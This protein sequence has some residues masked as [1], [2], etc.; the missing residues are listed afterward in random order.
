MPP[1]YYHHHSHYHHHYHQKV[2][3]GWQW[4]E[5]LRATLLL[6]DGR[7]GALHEKVLL[8][9]YSYVLYEWNVVIHILFTSNC[10]HDLLFGAVLSLN[11]DNMTLDPSRFDYRECN[12]SIFFPLKNVF[13]Q[14]VWVAV[15]KRRNYAT[16]WQRKRWFVSVCTVS[17]VCMYVVYVCRF[18]SLN[19]EYFAPGVF[20]IYTFVV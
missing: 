15:P 20:I 1:Y 14:C 11:A 8:I 3:H 12:F 9:E 10:R 16:C 6:Q 18:E 4:H 2:C 19:G 7:V 5:T 17:Y 13:W